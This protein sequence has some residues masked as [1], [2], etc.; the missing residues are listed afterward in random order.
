MAI[1]R[2][3]LER[4]EGSF[5]HAFTQMVVAEIEARREP[6]TRAKVEAA[7]QVAHEAAAKVYCAVYRKV[8][9][10]AMDASR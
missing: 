3:V 6:S 2:P 10:E 5:F 7:G 1:A 4:L 9:A 8:F